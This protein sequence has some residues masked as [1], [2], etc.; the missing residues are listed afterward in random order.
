MN[1]A[2]DSSPKNTSSGSRA[3]SARKSAGPPEDRKA[4]NQF[5]IITPHIESAV[6]PTLDHEVKGAYQLID[7]GKNRLSEKEKR[8]STEAE[9]AH[10]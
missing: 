4:A 2:A 8:S 3:Q 1:A 7:S 9:F 10:S 6:V 5:M